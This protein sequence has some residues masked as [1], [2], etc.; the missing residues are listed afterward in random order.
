[1]ARPGVGEGGEQ[2]SL[3]PAVWETGEDCVWGLSLDD[4]A[5]AFE[6]KVPSGVMDRAQSWPF[7]VFK[8]IIIPAFQT[9]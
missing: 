3:G 1:M 7:V 9:I 8:Q 6:Y 2:L 5:R 4:S